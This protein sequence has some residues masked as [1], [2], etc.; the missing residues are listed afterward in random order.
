[1][2]VDSVRDYWDSRPCNVRHSQ[3]D[4]DKYP[5]LYSWEVLCRKFRAEPH[6]VDFSEFPRWRGK[7]VCDLGC[8]IGTQSLCFASH[9][10]MVIGV[11]ISKQSLSIAHRRALATGLE[12]QIIWVAANIEDYAPTGLKETFDL[13]YA[14]GSIHHTPTPLK[15]VMSAHHL[16]KPGGTFKLMLYHRR[17]LKVLSI[18]V[19][20]CRQYFHWKSIDKVVALESEAQTGCPITYTYT[21]DSARAMLE[22]AGFC[23]ESLDI[24]HIFPYKVTDYIK[25]Q[26]VLAWPWNWLPGK[27]FNWLQHRLGWHLCI[28]A[29]KSPFQIG[30][31]NEH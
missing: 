2:T 30:E 4:I 12:K 10:A 1:M 23:I 16:L 5:V 25:G 28:T 9:G 8:G 21:K 20:N 26:Y 31:Q 22:R 7:E 24:E 6:I 11:D 14:F 15:A 17:S 19:R 27:W 29:R 18:L 3:A 13:V